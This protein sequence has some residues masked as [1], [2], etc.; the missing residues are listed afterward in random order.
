MKI[1]ILKTAIPTGEVVYRAGGEGGRVLVF[2]HGAGG[3]SKLFHYQL[4]YFSR[5]YRV[6]GVDLP[7]HGRSNAGQI[8]EWNDYGLAVRAVFEQENLRQGGRESVVLA[9]HSMGGAVSLDIYAGIRDMVKG[10]ILI[11]TGPVLPV[12]AKLTDMLENE[13]DSFVDFSL[14]MVFGR[15]GVLF[16]EMLKQSPPPLYKEIIR[17]DLEIC[18][19]VDYTAQL[20]TVTQPVL[21]V[22]NK[23]DKV[24][25]VENTAVMEGILKDARLVVYDKDGHVPFLDNHRE[26]N[27]TVDDFFKEIGF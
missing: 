17:N 22:A 27:S 5:Q 23:R 9:G 10:I 16:A 11:S 1:K 3:D 20:E 25:R 2:I 12:S 19:G 4:K 14:K 18:R 8:P 6:I 15:N 21:I 7:G 13:F 26:F 24:V